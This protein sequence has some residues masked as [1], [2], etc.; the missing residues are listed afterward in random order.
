[1]ANQAKSKARASHRPARVKD[2]KMLF[3]LEE[4][5]Q[6]RRWGLIMCR[7]GDRGGA[8]VTALLG[9][10]GRRFEVAAL[11]STDVREGP[12]GPEVFLPE[13]K[14]GGSATVPISPETFEA[15]GTWIKAVAL[16]RGAPLIPTTAGEFMHPATLWRLFKQSV[17]AAGIKRN[18][19]VHSTRH[20]AGFLV[21]RVTG[22]LT[23]VQEFLR[24]KNL[25]TTATWYRHIHMPDLRAALGKAGI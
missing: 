7:G 10:A 5:E 16:P 20:A 23:K 25:A 11:R 3:T 9:T 14:G 22:D 17:A 19:G 2:N 12:G 13:V 18:V 8:L 21:L 15:L 6:L 1:M 24:H 4:I